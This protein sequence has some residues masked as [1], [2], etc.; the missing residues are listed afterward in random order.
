VSVAEVCWLKT[1]STRL[2]IVRNIY[3]TIS[4]SL[5]FGNAAFCPRRGALIPQSRKLQVEN[6]GA[7]LARKLLTAVVMLILF[8]AAKSSQDHHP[9]GCG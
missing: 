5:D 7:I 4:S 2:A 6:W 9:C 1:R 3:S 8:P